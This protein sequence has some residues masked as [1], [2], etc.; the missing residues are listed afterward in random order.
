MN[1]VRENIFHISSKVKS[2]N[3][4]LVIL[5][6]INLVGMCQYGMRQTAE[7]ESQMTSVERITEYIQLPS[8]PAMDSL[9]Q[10]C[11]ENNWPAN[12]EIV[13]KD[14][15]FKYSEKGDFALQNLNLKIESKEKVGIV[16]RTGNVQLII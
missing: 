11:P 12:G 7:V 3:I 2:G 1:F 13:L 8:E 5:Y 16:G 15:S 10:Y 4:G 6:C 9:P 14:L